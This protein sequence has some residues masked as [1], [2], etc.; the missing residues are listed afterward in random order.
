[1]AA[2]SL[3]TSEPCEATLSLHSRSA[4]GQF[5]RSLAELLF[6][7]HRAAQSK[8]RSSRGR[9]GP[10]PMRAAMKSTRLRLPAGARNGSRSC[11]AVSYPKRA[12]RPRGLARRFIAVGRAPYVAV[13]AAR[14]HPRPILRVAGDRKMRPNREATG[15]SDYRATASLCPTAVGWITCA[16][17]WK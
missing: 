3:A 8:L 1:M 5:S 15:H 11:M 12:P 7:H 13:V 10:E 16:R 9:L 14:P 17:H 2:T 6:A 4:K